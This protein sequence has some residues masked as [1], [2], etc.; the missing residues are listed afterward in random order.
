MRNKMAVSDSD[1]NNRIEIYFFLFDFFILSFLFCF[2]FFII[3]IFFS[4]NI[5]CGTLYF[6]F[7][8][9]IK[10]INSTENYR[11]CDIGRVLSIFYILG[12]WDFFFLLK[13]AA[14]VV[15]GRLENI[16]KSKSK[17]LYSSGRTARNSCLRS[18]F[19]PTCTCFA[20]D[21]QR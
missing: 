6:Q 1:L 10:Y 5:K 20:R 13:P 19:H 14:Q 4:F 12:L 7:I 9:L 18:I 3:L 17:R 21:N 15:F 11:Y 16:F 8:L 2:V